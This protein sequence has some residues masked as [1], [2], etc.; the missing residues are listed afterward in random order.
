MRVLGL[1]LLG[2]IMPGDANLVDITW[3]VTENIVESPTEKINYFPILIRVV[4][5]PPKGSGPGTTLIRILKKIANFQN[6]D[7]FALKMCSR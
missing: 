4:R 6:I 1:L 2:Y 5:E 7:L 3:Q